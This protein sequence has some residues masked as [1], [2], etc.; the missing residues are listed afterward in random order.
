MPSDS[1]MYVVYW[2]PNGQDTYLYGSS[3]TFQ[4][5]GTVIFENERMPSGFS[6]RR[7]SSRTSFQTDRCE[8]SL[9]LLREGKRYMVKACMHVVPDGTVLLRVE[10]FDRQ[11]RRI[12]FRFLDEEEPCF[13]V[14]QGTWYYHMELI[15]S[16]FK[17][18][19]FYGLLIAPDNPV[20]R[21]TMEDWS[22]ENFTEM[23][24]QIGRRRMFW[25]GEDRAHE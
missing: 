7:W 20:M 17:R 2:D 23:A 4:K 6:I 22:A 3:L 19:I 10:F 12:S 9:P 11:K 5:D 1:T 13:D 24:E 8:P 16:G 14:P 18:L 15:A 21:G 25:P